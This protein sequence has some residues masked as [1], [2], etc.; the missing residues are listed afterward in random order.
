MDLDVIIVGSL[1]AGVIL[2]FGFVFYELLRRY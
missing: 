1:F 2:T